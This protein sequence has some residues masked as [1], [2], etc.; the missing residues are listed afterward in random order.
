MAILGGGLFLN[1]IVNLP[2][3]PANHPCPMLNTRKTDAAHAR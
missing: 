2:F 1:V 3:A